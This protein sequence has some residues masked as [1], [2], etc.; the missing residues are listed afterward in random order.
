VPHGSNYS[1]EL[2]IGKKVDGQWFKCG[3]TIDYDLTCI[4]TASCDSIRIILKA[5]PDTSTIKLPGPQVCCWQVFFL[6]ND[7]G[8]SCIRK[9]KLY[10][11]TSTD[12]TLIYENLNAGMFNFLD[13]TN[14]SVDTVCIT[15]TPMNPGLLHLLAKFYNENDSLLCQQ[16]ANAICSGMNPH[17]ILPRESGNSI[18]D[19]NDNK[20]PKSV[21]NPGDIIKE[22]SVKPNPTDNTSIITY[23]LNIDANI[24]LDVYNILGNKIIDLAQGLKIGGLYSSELNTSQFPAGLYLIVLKADCCIKSINLTVIK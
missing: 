14:N 22:L 12:T 24:S 2:T 20:K 6:S 8:Y 21:K 16:I 3:R 9:I 5:I 7:S 15:G 11:T 23:E 18:P 1:C 19:S 10:Q 17:H 13:T 4:K